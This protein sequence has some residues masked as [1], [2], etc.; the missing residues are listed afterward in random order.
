[1]KKLMI[2]GGAFNP[3][4]KGHEKILSAAVNEL[5]PDLII[6][7]PTAVS[8]HKQEGEVKFSHRVRMARV[9]KKFENVLISGFEGRGRKRRNYTIQSLKKIEKTHPGYEIYLLIGGDML[10]SFYTWSRCRRIISKAVITAAARK[11]DDELLLKTA[12]RVKRDG[13]RVLILE[14][15]PLVISSS[16]LRERIKDKEDVAEYIDENVLRY[17][18][19]HNLYK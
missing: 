3:P 13:G 9:F 7:L 17:I 10:E 15:E 2:F 18:E 14:Y 1:M 5:S 16:E 4:H 8:P 12:A 11:K 19:K 6:I